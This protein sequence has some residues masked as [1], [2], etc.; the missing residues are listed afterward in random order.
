M[1]K[2]AYTTEKAEALGFGFSK[3]RLAAIGAGG[4]NRTPDLLI[5]SQLLYLLSYT[6]AIRDAQDMMVG[7]T[8]LE[9]VTPCA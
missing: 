7:T 1:I 8:G 5:T 4:R 6:S 9:P 2:V 3:G